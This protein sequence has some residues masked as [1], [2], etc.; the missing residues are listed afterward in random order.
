MVNPPP[1]RGRQTY[2][3]VTMCWSIDRVA[4]RVNSSLRLLPAI[5]CAV[6]LLTP[7]ATVR[8]GV[9]LTG[10]PFSDTGW[11]LAG[12]SLDNGTYI[13]GGGNFSFDAYSAS[14]LLESGSALD[15]LDPN[16]K[17]GDVILGMG[18]VFVP[19]SG[20]AGDTGWATDGLGA[21][22]V[23][24]NISK[25]LRIVSKFGV[26]PSSWAASTVKPTSGNGQ[27]STSGGHGG[28]G[29]ILVGTQTGFLDQT[30]D[31]PTPAN[32]LV[33]PNEAQRYAAP[34]YSGTNVPFNIARL[35]F[36]LD[37]N[38]LVSSWEMLLN[39]TYLSSVSPYGDIPQ[40]GDRFDQALQ[41][42]SNAITDALVPSAELAVVP[43][44]A[45]LIVWSL[46]GLSLV[47]VRRL[48]ARRR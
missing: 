40:P 37:T 10:N 19:N 31:T 3:I 25:S 47:G 4:H 2:G 45:S 48:A 15:G 12:N 27:G 23:N 24:S 33:V 44:P 5:V 8:G 38:N 16:W 41:R 42:S 14:F 22:A 6:A 36:N 46:L 35:I 13:R 21:V 43:E 39:T 32:T 20:L 34:S 18:G 29:A 17:V 26:N 7:N 30:D 11:T 28:D 9:A 1:A